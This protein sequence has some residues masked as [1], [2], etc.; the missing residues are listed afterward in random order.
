MLKFVHTVRTR[1]LPRSALHNPHE[2]SWLRKKPPS[3]RSH[4]KRSPDRDLE[5]RLAVQFIAAV[6]GVEAF[7]DAFQGEDV[8]D[9]GAEVDV[10]VLEDRDGACEM[11]VAA[12]PDAFEA[13]IGAQEVPVRVYLDRANVDEVADLDED[14]VFF[15]QLQPFGEGREEAGSLDDH[16]GAGAARRHSQRHL[17]ALVGVGDGHDVDCLV[18]AEF[19]GEL[20][21]AGRAADDDQAARAADFG[22]DQAHH[23]D[24]SGSLDDD[25]VAD[26]DVAA[27]RAVHA[28]RERLGQDAHLRGASNLIMHDS[29][30]DR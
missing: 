8:A 22:R 28:D 20:Q 23:A 14:A 25:R 17:P 24:G 16:V 7:G 5:G 9:D 12:A 26:L 6:E 30:S 13:Q 19:A 29:G 21:A 10:A 15:H 11:V 4:P 1:C 3:A 27:Q 18:R 2:N